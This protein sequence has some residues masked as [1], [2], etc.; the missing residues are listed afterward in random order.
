[1]SV[2]FAR[3]T[4]FGIPLVT[5]LCALAMVSSIPYVHVMNRYVRGGRSFGYVARLVVL[6][7][8][9]IWWFQEML[10]LVFTFYAAYSPARL[11][12]ARVRRRKRETP[13][14]T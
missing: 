10:A 3:W 12:V 11:L 8:L 14:A 13:E 2:E 9:A 4:A 7:V 1:M 6:L 5:L